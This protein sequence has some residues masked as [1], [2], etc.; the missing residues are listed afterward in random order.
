MR[1][2]DDILFGFLTFFL[3]D[4]AVRLFSTSVVVPWAER[5]TTDKNRVESW[6]LFSEFLCLLVAIVLVWRYRKVLHCMCRT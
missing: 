2:L 6:K 5:R 3:A 1:D 4:R